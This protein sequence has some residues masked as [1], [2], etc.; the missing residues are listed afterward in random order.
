[1]IHLPTKVMLADDL[2]KSMLSV[3]FM[4][5][6][7]TGFWCTKLKDSKIRVR[8]ALRRLATYS[9]QDLQRNGFPLATGRLGEELELDEFALALDNLAD[10]VAPE[11]SVDVTF[12]SGFNSGS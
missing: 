5:Y 9:E 4:R 7:T 10:K 12:W 11:E 8:R 1:M 6:C 3:C 2:I